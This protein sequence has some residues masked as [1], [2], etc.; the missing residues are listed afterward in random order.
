MKRSSVNQRGESVSKITHLLLNVMT[1]W[2]RRDGFDFSFSELA[3]FAA[4]SRLIVDLHSCLWFVMM[5]QQHPIVMM[6]F[7]ADNVHM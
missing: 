7:K 4:K 5:Q 2:K 3:A 1:Q 6:A